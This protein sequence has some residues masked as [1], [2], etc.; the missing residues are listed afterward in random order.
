[1]RSALLFHEAGDGAHQ[2]VLGEDLETRVAHLDKD[3]GILMAEDVCDALDRRG[4]RHLRQRIAH[5]FANHELAK[6]LALQGQV[7]DLVLVDRADGKILLEHRNL[8]NVLLLHGLQR[9]KHRLVRPR[10]DEFAHLAG[11][12]L[13]V[14]DFSHGNGGSCVDVAALEHPQVVVNLAEVARAGVR[15]QRNYEIFRSQIFGKAQ[16]PGDTA[17]AGAAREEPFQLRQP[18]R[19]DKT[20]LIID[21]DD[22]VQNFQIHGRGEEIFADA[23][24]DVRLGLDGLPGLDELVVE[25]TV[26]VHAN[27]FDVGIF[28]LQVFSRAANGAAGAH[29]ADEVRDLAFAVFP[30]LGTGG[31]VVRL[32]IHRVVVLIR[33]IR[34]GNLASEF[35]RYRIVAPGIFRLDGGG[36]N[37]DFGAESFQE[38]N[39]FFGLL[40]RG[41]KN[42]LVTANRR[43]QRQAHAGVAG[44]AFYNRAAG[45]EQ[46][47]L[48]GFI[49]HADA[50]AIF[51][52]AAGIGEFRLD[53]N[54]RLQAPIDAVQAHQRGV[55]NRFQN[56]VALHQ[57]SR[58][59]RRI[60]ISLASSRGVPLLSGGNHFLTFKQ[61]ESR[62]SFP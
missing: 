26:G 5:H 17:A 44:S 36:A 41:G 20:F 23:F 60:A 55:T 31:A 1:M 43:D 18:A 59:L 10:N 22:V 3:R 58:F 14:D 6:I 40:V 24:H 39:F 52:G 37:D 9:V 19:D 4:S 54:L 8:R 30:N 46:A 21:L 56:V 38:I 62:L 35:F 25:R 2:I 7:E 27:N 11:S 45:L 61:E 42:T 50:D 51:H 48:L 12:V 47:F 16:C 33:I 53:V 29:A 32:G 13:G 34:I 49:D 57:S 28:F 15:Q